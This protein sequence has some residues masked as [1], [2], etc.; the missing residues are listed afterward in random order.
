MMITIQ[1]ADLK[2]NLFEYL[3]KIENGETIVIRHNNQNVA[4]LVP[5]VKSDWRSRMKVQPKLLVSPEKV[6]EPAEDI[7]EEYI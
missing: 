3:S 7:W 1:A 6:I 4:F 2:D 5:P